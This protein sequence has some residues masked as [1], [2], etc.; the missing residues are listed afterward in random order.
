MHYL[1]IALALTATAN[2]SGDWTKVAESDVLTLY[3]DLE[4]IEVDGEVT[5]YWELQDRK[6]PSPSGYLSAHYQM[7]FDCKD[8]NS[9]LLLI[10]LYSGQMLTGQL[11]AERDT[12]DHSWGEWRSLGQDTG[13]REVFRLICGASWP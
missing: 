10:R 5:R 8:Q 4:A 2:A 13:E 12:T 1:L 9:R 11:R 3:V 7:E 6:E